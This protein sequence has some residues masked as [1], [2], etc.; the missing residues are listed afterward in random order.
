MKTLIPPNHRAMALL[1]AFSLTLVTGLA[2]AT[3]GGVDKNGCHNS[4]KAG[5]HCHPERAKNS[6]DGGRP[7]HCR[8]T[9]PKPN[10]TSD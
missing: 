7:G 2:H 9:E 1:A 10:G 3:S 4:A 8:A 5:F 6:G